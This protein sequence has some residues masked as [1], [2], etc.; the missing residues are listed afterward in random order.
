[1]QYLPVGLLKKV[2]PF[3]RR[4]CSPRPA[5]RPPVSEFESPKLKIAVKLQDPSLESAAMNIDEAPL[6]IKSKLPTS[7]SKGT[8]T[9]NVLDSIM[10]RIDT[11]LPLPRN[12]NCTK[13]Y[14][15]WMMN[16]TL[17]GWLFVCMCRFPPLL[18][19]PHSKERLH[20]QAFN[21]NLSGRN[22]AFISIN[23]LVQTG[24]MSLKYKYRP[25]CNVKI[26]RELQRISRIPKVLFRY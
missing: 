21:S 17:P 20:Y 23:V 9:K 3:G 8:T 22:K 24:R 14:N 6:D 7:T 10:P 18:L 11:L 15:E 4:E 12:A 19:S 26:K 16:L 1:M 25:G 5:T 2:S 13:K